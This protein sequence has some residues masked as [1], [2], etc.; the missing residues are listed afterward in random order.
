MLKLNAG[1]ALQ[2]FLV[3][4][5][6]A[7]GY[8]WY[9]LGGESLSEGLRRFKRG[10][11]GGEGALSR[12]MSITSFPAAPRDAWSPRWFLAFVPPSDFI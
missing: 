7:R 2:W 4:R 6:S 11:V 3:E 1:Y 10:L 12:P 9:D 8:Q 5:L